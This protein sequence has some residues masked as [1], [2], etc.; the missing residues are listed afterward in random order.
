MGI[1]PT[2]DRK[3]IETSFSSKCPQLHSKHSWSHTFFLKCFLNWLIDQLVIFMSIWVKSTFFPYNVNLGKK[4]FRDEK[5]LECN[6]GHFGEN[7]KSLRPSYQKLVFCIY[8][9]MGVAVS[10]F[11]PILKI[12]YPLQMYSVW[13]LLTNPS[14]FCC[15]IKGSYSIWLSYYSI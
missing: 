11:S 9:E 4:V 3:V 13:C 12:L 8:K 10:G 2:F 1:I 6:C 14:E 7:Q 5:C 15:H